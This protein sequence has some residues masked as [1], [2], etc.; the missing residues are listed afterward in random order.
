[1]IVCLIQMSAIEGH[2]DLS[3]IPQT[4][5]KVLVVRNRLTSI[6]GLDQLSCKDL[7]FLDIRGN[8]LQ[9][10]LDSLLRSSQTT[11]SPLKFFQVSANQISRNLV[12]KEMPKR[13]NWKQESTILRE[14]SQALLRWIES[15]SLDCIVVG[16]KRP[17]VFWGGNLVHGQSG[18]IPL[19]SLPYV[20]PKSLQQIL[21]SG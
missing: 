6:S 16:Q 19:Q 3:A 14:L 21:N 7:S 20:K 4:V 18:L 9:I 10:E 11:V 8:P 5:K 15:S 1:M 2:L 12:G 17:R 13:E